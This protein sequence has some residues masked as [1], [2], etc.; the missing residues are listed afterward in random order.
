MKKLT[1]RQIRW[2]IL[3]PFL[4]VLL[5]F[6][7]NG[8][9]WRVLK[10]AVRV[11]QG[12]PVIITLDSDPAKAGRIHG[13]QL[14]IAIKLLEKL[15]IQ[16]SV[17]Q[18]SYEKLTAQA[19][20]LFASIDPRWTREATALAEKSSAGLDAMML[21]NCFLDI[22][23]YRNGCRQLLTV[24]P[25]GKVFHTHNL[26]WDG[27]AGVGQYWVTVFRV[28]AGEGRLATV[29]F[30]FP[31]MIGALDVINSEGVAL[32][33]NQ[34][35]FSR[36]ESKMPVFMK[37]REIAE[38]CP[39]FKSAETMIMN[40]EQGMPFCIG[41]SHAK[42]GQ[43]A[44]Y[45]RNR[46]GTVSKREPLDGL[47]TADN[48]I[49]TGKLI[50]DNTMDKVARAAMPLTTPDDIKAIMRSKTV[51]LGS[52]M[53]SVIFDFQANKFHLAPGDIPAATGQYRTYRLFE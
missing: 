14:R 6:T 47:I 23:H 43:I 8:D 26:D 40:M 12:K 25:G 9:L 2:I 33:F 3:S 17:G 37:M 5:F 38:K 28:P 41:L 53:Y 48:T 15:Y 35:G 45:E 21:G 22:G 30:G 20:E 36:Q 39:D 44:V 24:T 34:H 32:S 13:S 46:D 42:S 29:Y 1:K 31:G 49:Q 52:N 16:N 27:L 11:P 4:L 50:T 19:R 51:L 10:I 18:D 7:L